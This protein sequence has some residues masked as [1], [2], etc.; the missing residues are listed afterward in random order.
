MF[1]NIV[2]NKTIFCFLMTSTK[3]HH[4]YFENHCKTS[5]SVVH[6]VIACDFHLGFSILDQNVNTNS[7]DCAQSR[8]LNYCHEQWAVR[9]QVW[10]IKDLVPFISLLE[11]WWAQ[12]L[13]VTEWGKINIYY[14]FTTFVG[15]STVVTRL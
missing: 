12:L 7:S 11:P 14:Y 13:T 8:R 1:E 9:K 2:V 3:N 5:S 15:T 6:F 4:R 10:Y